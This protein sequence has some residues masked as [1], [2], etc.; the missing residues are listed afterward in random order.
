MIRIKRAVPRIKVEFALMLL[1]FATVSADAE[2]AKNCTP[3][4]QV[5]KN[6]SIGSPKTA[7]EQKADEII[8]YCGAAS[9][10]QSLVD[11]GAQS[12]LKKE[13]KSSTSID[14]IIEAIAK[15]LASIAWPIAVVIIAYHFKIELAALLTRLRKFKAGNTE[16]EFG[17]LLREAEDDVDIERT[18]EAQSVTPEVIASAASNPRGSILSAWLEVETAVHHLYNAKG[19]SREVLHS[20]R[21]RSIGPMVLMREIQKAEALDQNYISLFHDLR[22]LRNDAAHDIDFNPPPSDVVRYIQLARELAGAINR[23]ADGN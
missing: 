6:F 21:G 9:S 2:E 12:M 17:E 5:R 3:P 16:A 19:L 1:V 11:N 14:K 23:A 15:V 22:T 13:S 7:V 20:P 8:V 4:Q 10:T 18:P